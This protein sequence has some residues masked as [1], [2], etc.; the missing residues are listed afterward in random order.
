[1]NQKA[2]RSPSYPPV[3]LKEAVERVGALHKAIANNPTSREV[4]AKGLGYGGLSGASATMIGALNKYGLLEGRG[5]DVRVSDRAMAIL[6]PHNDYERRKALQ[7]AALEPELF[8]ELHERFPGNLPSLDLLRNYLLRNKFTPNAV[9]AAILAYKETFEFVGGFGSVHDPVV[10]PKEP[11]EQTV[12]M[13]PQAAAQAPQTKTFV[14]QQDT[15]PIGDMLLG[16][17][18]FTGGGRLQI[19]VSPDVDTEEAL[20]MAQTL[21]ELR[22]KELARKRGG[23]KGGGQGDQNA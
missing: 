4:V 5:D 21:I 2:A 14:N 17:W 15:S 13:S 16:R 6:H 19:F 18:D 11:K 12:M 9:D 20:D 23:P 1:M 7:E 22:R 3:S 10:P 8:R